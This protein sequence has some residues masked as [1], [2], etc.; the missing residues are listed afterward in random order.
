LGVHR[1]LRYGVECGKL[2]KV[3][4]L[5]LLDVADQP[6]EFYSDVELAE[7]LERARGDV[8]LTCALMLGCDAGLRAGE[9][10]ALHRVNVGNGKLIVMHSEYAGHLKQPKGRRSRTVPMTPR[11]AAV[12]HAATRQHL[13]PR[14]LARIDGLPWSKEIMRRVA[15]SKGWHALRHTFCS[16]L[17]APGVPATQIQALAGHASIA[18]TQRYMHHGPDALEAAV[19]VLDDSRAENGNA[20][21]GA[22]SGAFGQI[23][24]NGK[25]AV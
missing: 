13:G 5:G 6:F 12:V 20:P 1:G 24:A 15:P 23:L 4:D 17:A 10:R 9:I 25:L 11:L 18:T 8:M 3:P 2:E 22:T 16:R 7:L 14:V 19:S 21:E